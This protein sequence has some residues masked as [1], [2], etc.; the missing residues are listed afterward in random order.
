[1]KSLKIRLDVLGLNHVDVALSYN[2]IGLV[3]RSKGDYK[4]ALE[5]YIKSL[6]IYINVLG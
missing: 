1:M 2:N 6:K 3:Y 4:L 5:Y